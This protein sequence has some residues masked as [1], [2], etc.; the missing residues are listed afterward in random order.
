MSKIV[1]IGPRKKTQQLRT[2][3]PDDLGSAPTFFIWLLITVY[4]SRSSGSDASS[5]LCRNPYTCGMHANR[6]IR[7]CLK[8][9]NILNFS[10][11]LC[12][13]T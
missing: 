9:S 12:V 10:R 13:F 8:G 6:L 1:N 2:A 11:L 4:Q 7:L 3:L 5:G